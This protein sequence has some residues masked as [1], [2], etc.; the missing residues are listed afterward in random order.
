MPGRGSGSPRRGLRR[1]ARWVRS[2]SGRRRWR[3]RPDRRGDRLPQSRIR[4]V[5]DNYPASEELRREIHTGLQ[6]G[7]FLLLDEAQDT[8]PVVEQVCNAQRGHTQWVMVGST[9]TSSLCRAPSA[10]VNTW[11]VKPTG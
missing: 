11:P 10:S 2:R 1:V 9:A 7:D 3:R 6:A 5:I 8:N 4:E